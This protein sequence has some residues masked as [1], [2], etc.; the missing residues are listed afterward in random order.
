VW[1]V[2]WTAVPVVVKDVLGKKVGGGA[3]IVR[4]DGGVGERMERLLVFV[5][6]RVVGMERVLDPAAT[7]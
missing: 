2:V 7:V 4:D 6:L 1:Q 5:A 3:E